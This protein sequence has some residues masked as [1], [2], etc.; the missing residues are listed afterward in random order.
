MRSP[1]PS[2]Q[3]IVIRCRIFCIQPKENSPQQENEWRS[4]VTKGMVLNLWSLWDCFLDGSYTTYS[5]YSLSSTQHALPTSNIDVVYHE[6][7]FHQANTSAYKFKYLIAPALAQ[8]STPTNTQPYK[9]APCESPNQT[10]QLLPKSNTRFS[11]SARNV[12][13]R[14]RETQNKDSQLCFSRNKT[15]A[16]N[17]TPRYSPSRPKTHTHERPSSSPLNTTLNNKEPIPPI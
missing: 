17:E 10:H 4:S 8:R 11:I 6:I 3:F 14:S 13:T 12:K 9:L 7:S 15:H 16:L 2:L 5:S 1:S